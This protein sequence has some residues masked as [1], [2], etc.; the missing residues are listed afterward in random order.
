MVNQS[1][2]GV[3]GNRKRQCTCDN[4]AYI[5]H[6]FASWFRT[7][8]I[9]CSRFQL[10][11]LYSQVKILSLAIPFDDDNKYVKQDR[12]TTTTRFFLFNR[13]R[14]KSL[15]SVGS[16]RNLLSSLVITAVDVWALLMNRRSSDGFKTRYFFPQLP[17]FLAHS[18]K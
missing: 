12:Y 18:Y 6:V 16:R 10:H 15:H 5:L 3:L 9:L 2:H 1:L 7:A 8:Y 17:S 13:G 11:H 4:L 14:L